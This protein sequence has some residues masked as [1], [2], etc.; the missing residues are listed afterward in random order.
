MPN[1][2]PENWVGLL[3]SV[4]PVGTTKPKLGGRK[5]SLLV[6]S[7]ENTRD[8]PKSSFSLNS[9]KL[10]VCAYSGSGLEQRRSQHRT[11]AKV[12]RVQALVD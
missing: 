8:L 6:E 2:L 7:K 4:E 5:D 11:G 3:V 1:L 10:S 9:F 12:N